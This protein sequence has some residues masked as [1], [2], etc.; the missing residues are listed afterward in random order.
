MCRSESTQQH[1]RNVYLNLTLTAMAAAL[2]SHLSLIRVLPNPGALALTIPVVGSTVAISLLPRSYRMTRHALLY[3]F[4]FANGWAIGPLLRQLLYINPSVPLMAL[5][6]AAVIFLSFSMTAMMT[7]RRSQL[8]LGGFLASGMLVLIAM[9]LLNTILGS[10]GSL[11]SA[12]L[13]LGLLMLAGYTVYDTQVMVELAEQNRA[14]VP[15]DAL[16]LFTNL[17]GIF[18]RLLIIFSRQNEER[19]RRK[20]RKSS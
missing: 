20:R 6:G 13:Y 18:L 9:G 14:D 17:F 2:A 15:R 7:E 8:Y 12:E 4:G 16:N 3:V 19:E 11:F 5:V 10:T 1:L